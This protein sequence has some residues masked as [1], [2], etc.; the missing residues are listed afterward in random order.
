LK[1]KITVFLLILLLLSVSGC[2]FLQST[3]GPPRKAELAIIQQELTQDEEGNVIYLVSVKNI[4]QVTV[5]LAEIEVSFYDSQD[6]FIGSTTD[7]VLNLRPDDTWDFYIQCQ[8]DC[9]DIQRCDVQ[10]TVGTSSGIIP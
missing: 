3:E 1:Y 7:S 4:S 10:V 6:N 2:S 8:G 5:E 9:R